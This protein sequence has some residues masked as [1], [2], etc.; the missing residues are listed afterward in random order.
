MYFDKTTRKSEAFLRPGV[1]ADRN[2]RASPAVNDA[3]PP[4]FLCVAYRFLRTYEAL[5]QALFVK[6]SLVI[7]PAPWITCQCFIH[8]NIVTPREGTRPTR[9]CRPRALTRRGNS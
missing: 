5:C 4:P 8:N 7:L 3:L 2:A 1:A 6:G 9:S